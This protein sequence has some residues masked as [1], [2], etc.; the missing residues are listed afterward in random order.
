MTPRCLESYFEILSYHLQVVTKNE[1]TSFT[2]YF[3][4]PYSMTSAVGKVT[5]GQKSVVSSVQLM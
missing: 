4:I 2:F 5:K 1:V 3:L